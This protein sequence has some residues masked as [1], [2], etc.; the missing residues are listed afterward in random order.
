MARKGAMVGKNAETRLGAAS[1]S[2]LRRGESAKTQPKAKTPT[3]PFPSHFLE[4]YLF[5]LHH[6][7]VDESM[8]SLDKCTVACHGG[9]SRV[10]TATKSRTVAGNVK[11]TCDTGTNLRISTRSGV[12][13]KPAINLHMRASH[14]SMFKFIRLR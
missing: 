10:V 1:P 13:V 8:K 5:Q 4:V 7:M 2:C 11:M 12:I 3:N 14:P 6:W 9:A